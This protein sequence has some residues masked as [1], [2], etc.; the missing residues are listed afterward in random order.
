[1]NTMLFRKFSMSS[2]SGAS[3][4]AACIFIHG[5]GTLLQAQGP[6]LANVTGA[7]ASTVVQTQSYAKYQEAVEL[8]KK[9]IL[10]V[11]NTEATQGTAIGKSY[12]GT[13]TLPEAKNGQSFICLMT[14]VSD[15]GC[16]MTID[17]TA[18]PWLKEYGQGHDISKGARPW[19][20]VFVSGKTYDIKLH[21]SQTWYK[22]G[23]NDLDGISVVLCVLPIDLA[24][25]ANRD[26]TIAPGEHASQESP[27]RFWINNDSDKTETEK[28]DEGTTPDYKSGRINNTRDL[29][30]FNM[31]KLTI[32]K[33][34]WNMHLHGKAS[35]G[36]KWKNISGACPGVKV[37]RVAGAINESK[38]YLWNLS[39]ADTEM[40]EQEVFGKDGMASIENTSAVRL[41]NLILTHS[42]EDAQSYLQVRLLFEGSGK[43]KGQLCLVFLNNGT[44]IFEGPGVWLDLVDAL[45]MFE[46]V[47]G[48]PPKPYPNPPNYINHEPS[49]PSTDYE[50]ITWPGRTEFKPAKDESDEAI[51]LVHGWNMNDSDRRTFCSSF[52]KRIWWRGFKGR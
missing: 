12:D 30:D 52:F 26:G 29:E 48:T 19:P 25:D 13:L 7:F 43:G 14:L 33:E 39:K 46:S 18:E 42:T 16:D 3:L 20:G 23:V 31:L 11:K 2:V 49:R 24:V 38:E 44:E 9:G 10:M 17:N 5:S 51:I 6:P 45:E 47:N 32:P 8:A 22:P 40:R 28:E 4:I 35:I 41:S 27:L 34:I 36:L 50:K 37:F 15:D 1:M 21:Y